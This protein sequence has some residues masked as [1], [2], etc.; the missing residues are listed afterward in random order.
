MDTD[1]RRYS[2]PYNTRHISTI[3]T[4][5]I[6]IIIIITSN[7]KRVKIVIAAAFCVITVLVLVVEPRPWE[8][9]RKIM[10]WSSQG[11][12]QRNFTQT[13]LILS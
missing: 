5:I 11:E 12:Y 6:I 4:T 9:S 7:I 8:E 2:R 10:F 3:N 1:R 13:K